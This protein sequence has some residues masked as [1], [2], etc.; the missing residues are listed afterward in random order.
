MGS[1]VSRSQ[2]S[3]T[4][5]LR[6]ARKASCHNLLPAPVAVY[7]RHLDA[8][9]LCR[10]LSTSNAAEQLASSSPASSSPLA[11]IRILDLSRILAGPYCSQLLCDYGADVIKVEQPGSGDDTRSWGPPFTD[12]GG[13]SAYFLSVNRGKRSV[14]IDLKAERGKQLIRQLAVQCDVLMENFVPGKVSRC[15]QSQADPADH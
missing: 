9:V 15:H 13:M 1:S 2:M 10:H 6:A 7:R 5:V 3:V 8:F 12:R 4:A 14:C 11:G